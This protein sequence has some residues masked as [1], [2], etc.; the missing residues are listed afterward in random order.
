MSEKGQEVFSET[1]NCVPILLSMQQDENATWRQSLSGVDQSAFI[2]SEG[3]GYTYILSTYARG[4]D[5][6]KER[7]IYNKVGQLIGEISNEQYG[8]AAMLDGLLDSLSFPDNVEVL[9]LLRR[10]AHTSKKAVAVLMSNAELAVQFADRIWSVDKN[11]GFNSGIPEDLFLRGVVDEC[12]GNERI[13]YD[14]STGRFVYSGDH[15]RSVI[16]EGDVAGKEYTPETLAELGNITHITTEN[17]SSTTIANNGG[18]YFIDSDVTLENAS[19]GGWNKVRLIGNTIG[20]RTHITMTSHLAMNTANGNV[21]FF[22]LEFTDPRNSGNYLFTSNFNGAFEYLAF[23]NCKFNMRSISF[24][25]SG[26][27]NSNVRSV[28]NLAIENCIFEFP[29]TASG[30]L[31]ILAL[32]GAIAAETHIASMRYKNNIFYCAEGTAQNFQLAFTSN[33]ETNPIT[34]DRLTIENNTFVNLTPTTVGIVQTRNISDLVMRNNLFWIEHDNAG[35]YVINCTGN[36]P[37]GSVCA[38]NIGYSANSKTEFTTFTGNK[39]WSGAENISALSSD[40]YSGGTFNLQEG[41]F[42]PNSSNLQYG[43]TIGR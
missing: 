16:V 42:I 15:I 37:T 12:F 19:T 10:M 18:T 33:G 24:F 25:S 39:G 23:D 21:E 28:N 35:Y 43:S 5:Q 31:R 34:I 2:R 4:Y 9:C 6:S 36:A 7:G 8:T 17:A 20:T 3:D 14:I 22:N 41:I 32:T 13:S 1:G 40:P 30:N 26:L 27:S 38:Q 29:A 11:R